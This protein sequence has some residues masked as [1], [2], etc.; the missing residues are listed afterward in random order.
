MHYYYLC[1]P[2]KIDRELADPPSIIMRPILL[3]GHE[4]SIT[5]VRY[6]REG[7]LLFTCSKDK[8]PQLWYSDNGERIGTY[9]GHNGTVWGCDVSCKSF[10][11][12]SSLGLCLNLRVTFSYGPT[13]QSGIVCQSRPEIGGWCFLS[14]SCYVLDFFVSFSIVYDYVILV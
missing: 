10:S 9:E 12:F 3:Q 11:S 13:S 2:S 6:N 1:I 5:Y 14:L 8:T 7:D 4:R